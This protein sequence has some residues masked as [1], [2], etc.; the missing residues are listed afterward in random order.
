[1][2]LNYVYDPEFLSIKALPSQMKQIVLDRCTD[3]NQWE[4]NSLRSQFIDQ[5]DMTLLNRGIEYN[6]W[7]DNN[8]RVEFAKIFPEWYKVLNEQA[9]VK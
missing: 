2:H 8:N 5:A 1:V 7:L 4:L 6:N 3:L 9:F